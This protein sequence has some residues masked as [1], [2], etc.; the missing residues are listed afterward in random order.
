MPR[1]KSGVK[2]KSKKVRS[3]KKREKKVR[4]TTTEEF[5]VDEENA[6]NQPE[7]EHVEEEPQENVGE[8][9]KEEKQEEEL[10]SFV[11]ELFSQFEESQ[12]ENWF[13]AIDRYG[14][15]Y[16][17]D[18]IRLRTKEIRRFPG[19][20]IGLDEIEA[21][22]QQENRGGT[23]QI[24][25]C[26][27]NN[28]I[29][30]RRK[31]KIEG[32]AKATPEDIKFHEET[33]GKIVREE[34]A[35]SENVEDEEKRLRMETRKYEL[36]TQ[37]ER[38]RREYEREKRRLD[39][40][41]EM[42]SNED[43]EDDDEGD[44]TDDRLSRRGPLTPEE[45]AE[46]EG[47]P[48]RSRR[49]PRSS[50]D[51]ERELN[52]KYENRELKSKLSR[53]EERIEAVQ[54]TM[55]ARPVEK[56]GKGFDIEGF[57]PI[58]IEAIKALKPT[59]PQVDPQVEALKEMVR[60]LANRIDRPQADPVDV[61]MKMAKIIK[62]EGDS[63]GGVKTMFETMLPLVTTQMQS[64]NAMLMD[65]MREMNKTQ[66]EIMRQGVTQLLEGDKGET[67][68]WKTT[69]LKKGLDTVET[70][71]KEIVGFNKE[72]L[73]IEQRRLELIERGRIVPTGQKQVTAG[74]RP[75][76]QARRQVAPPQPVAKR[77]VAPVQPSPASPGKAVAPEPPKSEVAGVSNEKVQEIYTLANNLL[78]AAIQAFLKDEDPAE[79]AKQT[80]EIGGP[81]VTE[82]LLESE[83]IS[84][85]EGLAK[86][87][88]QEAMYNKWI[89]SNMLVKTW[90][91]KWIDAVK[92]SYR[93]EGEEA[94]EEEPVAEAATEPVEPV[95]PRK[96]GKMED[97]LK[98]VRTARKTVKK[99][100]LPVAVKKKTKKT[101]KS[102][103][104]SE[105]I[106]REKM[107]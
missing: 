25:V 88:G 102:K 68:D 65:S 33:L 84:A 81:D 48:L 18:N 94:E 61:A 82:W 31:F 22:I 30:K 14:P 95:K 62:G 43:R 7:E 56:S 69:A 104:V 6:E 13:I 57:A 101:G 58:I 53:M 107:A 98:P 27:H 79:F 89:A 42:E 91:N 41:E 63:T 72:K 80:L 28:R 3:G 83:G 19:L 46:M 99:E 45:I 1:E 2:D 32:P 103:K 12:L 23:Y 9:I 4:R 37:A 93:F 67:D 75:A 44:E 85:I 20:D 29:R 64:G 86:E 76:Q 49:Q 21:T 16:T 26:D 35:K 78:Q 96:R 70:F 5:V 73:N 92:S 34:R 17:D 55:K 105:K 24:R 71:G 11:K 8:Q 47:M 74:K 15:A 38:A 60:D 52:L 51:I 50:E 106:V 97:K 10:P 77:P 66:S 39:R 100:K 87:F 40:L 36:K 59:Q 90:L 54:D